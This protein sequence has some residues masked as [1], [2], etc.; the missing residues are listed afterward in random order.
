MPSV[1]IPYNGLQRY[2]FRRRFGYGEWEFPSFVVHW[3]FG[4]CFCSMWMRAVFGLGPLYVSL[5]VLYLLY[6]A[7]HEYIGMTNGY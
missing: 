5:P 3:L 1:Y 7:A 6:L 4:S 2:A